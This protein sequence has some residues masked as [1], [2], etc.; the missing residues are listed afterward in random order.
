MTRNT[1]IILGIVCSNIKRYIF[2]FYGYSRHSD[3][4]T[5]TRLTLQVCHVELCLNGNALSAKVCHG[6]DNSCAQ[7]ATGTVVFEIPRVTVE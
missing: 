1:R 2:T 7:L 6:A 5:H 3:L 4:L